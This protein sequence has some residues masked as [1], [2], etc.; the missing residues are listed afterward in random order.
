[1]STTA[2]KSRIPLPT[3]IKILGKI[4]QVSYVPTLI[5]AETKEELFGETHG[6][7]FKIEIS[8]RFPRDIQEKTLFHEAMHAAL[9]VAGLDHIL[10][11]RVEEAIISCLENAFSDVVNV[12]SLAV[13]SNDKPVI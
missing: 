3:Q 7:D 10:E 5:D 11:D 9:S 12:H 13:D 4:F 6:R 8:T 1:M 2:K